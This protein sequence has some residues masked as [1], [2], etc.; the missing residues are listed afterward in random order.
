MPDAPQRVAILTDAWHPQVS[1]VVT[2]L[3][4]MVDGLREQGKEVLVVHP[5][6]FPGLPCPTYPDIRLALLPGFRLRRM[7]EAFRPDAVHIPVEGPIGLAGRRWCLKGGHPF[8]TS[9]MTKFPEYINKRTGLPVKTL[10]R[11][12]RWFHAPAAKTTVS[13]QSLK[14][15]LAHRG[16]RNLVY[17]GRGVDCDLFR[18]RPK[19]RIDFA[20]PVSLYVGR[21]AVEKNLEA[22]LSLDLPGSKV[23]IGDGP[24]LERLTTEYPGVHFLG[25]KTG[26]DLAEHVAA[27]DV[28]VFPSLTDTFGIVLIEAMASGLPVAAYPVMGPIDVVAHGRTGWLDKD[29]ARAVRKCLDLSPGDC[30]EHA[31]G[32]SWQRSLEQY[33]DSL[34]P[35]P[36]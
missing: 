16:F 18:P 17:W 9:F 3:G 13:T 22:F 24:A 2:A 27:A 8:T 6:Q 7:L 35:F 20:R 19:D 15:E 36:A 29:L 4:K 32:Y 28:F 26:E 21:V 12:Y 31:L 5:G 30:R 25:R 33:Q 11:G 34:V 10:Y 14:Q 23:V 1:G